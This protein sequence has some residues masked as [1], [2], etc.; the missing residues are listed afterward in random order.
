MRKLSQGMDEPASQ[1]KQ[2]AQPEGVKECWWGLHSLSRIWY[3]GEDVV[4]YLNVF[5]E[6]EKREWT[7]SQADTINLGLLESPVINRQP[8]DSPTCCFI[9]IHIF[10]LDVPWLG[11]W[12]TNPELGPTCASKNEVPLWVE[13]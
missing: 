10:F 12:R 7:P 8:Q 9:Y 2:T 4:L 11:V 13:C 3:G 5:W 6:Q 1:A